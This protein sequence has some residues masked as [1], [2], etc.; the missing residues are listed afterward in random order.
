MKEKKLPKGKPENMITEAL[1]AN[2]IT[3]LE[4]ASLKK[5]RE[6]WLDAIQVDSFEL[7]D[8]SSYQME[9]SII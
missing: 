3:E 9:K 2:I 7:D 1:E 6:V 4:A 8:Y 5:A